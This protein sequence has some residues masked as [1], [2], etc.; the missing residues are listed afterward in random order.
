MVIVTYMAK[1]GNHLSS[2]GIAI[3]NSRSEPLPDH[4]NGSNTQYSPKNAALGTCSIVFPQ[5]LALLDYQRTL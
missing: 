5:S 2:E 4:R 3:T 1:V